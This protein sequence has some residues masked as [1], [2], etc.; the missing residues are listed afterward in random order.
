MGNKHK[1]IKFIKLKLDQFIAPKRRALSSRWP[2]LAKP[3]IGFKKFL[4]CLQSL[5]RVFNR[6]QSGFYF[7]PY[8][9]KKHQS[10]LIKKL[11]NSD[12]RLQYQ[13]VQNL[14]LA[15]AK[16][17]GL[18]IKPGQTFSLW[19]A[20]GAPIAKRGFVPG[21]LLSGGVVKEGVGGGL[22]QMANLLYWMFLHTPLEIVEHHHHSMDIFPDSGRVLPFG[23]GATIYYNYFDLQVK[24]TTDKP[25][26]L[27]V[28]LTDE[29]L[30]GQV[31]SPRPLGESYSV[32]E[33]NH[34]FVKCLDRYF[35]YNEIWRQKSVN[36]QVIDY[37]K[38]TVNFS[39]VL[40]QVTDDYLCKNKFQVIEF[41]TALQPRTIEQTEALA[42]I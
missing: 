31:L 29:H 21:M 15:A 28:W 4:R 19:Q 41:E 22:C 11:G 32:F 13:K 7:F 42:V 38:I 26:Q 16:L 8:S 30:K 20:V 18:I 5:P 27:K 40:Y 37:E 1:I 36:G 17:N 6:P 25:L 14:R 12:M 10:V 33:K 39:P 24:N 34:Y 2:F 35:R 9:V 3:I 23:S